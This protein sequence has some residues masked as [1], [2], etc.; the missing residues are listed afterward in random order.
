V[1]SGSA[2]RQL[3]VDRIRKLTH[4]GLAIEIETPRTYKES[5]DLFRIGKAEINANPDG[6]DFSGAAYESLAVAGL[7]NREV[8]LDTSSI[9]YL[10]GINSIMASADTAV[11][12]VWL[13][14]D[15]NTRV[16]QLNAGRDW[17]RINL[18]T[19]ELGIGV[20]PMSQCLQ[21]YPEMDNQFAD[22][23]QLLQVEGKTIQMLGRLGY[24]APVPR[25]PRWSIESKII[26]A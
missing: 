2:F 4:R 17:L 20:H 11:A 8:A 9:S 10:E 6:I 26:K 24:A 5:V 19:T 21:E 16:D 14:T 1:D 22:M 7:F 18:M 25:S 23:Q 13:T 15:T 3:V 12:Y